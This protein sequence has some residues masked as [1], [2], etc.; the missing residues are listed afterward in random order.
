LTTGNHS[1]VTAKPSLAY[2]ICS[3]YTVV[4]SLV[5]I[6]N[7]VMN[8]QLSHSEKKPLRLNKYAVARLTLT[9]RQMG[10]IVA[11]NQGETQPQTGSNGIT[12][13]GNPC[14]TLPTV[15]HVTTGACTL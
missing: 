4:L 6:K 1:F 10:L 8:K 13:D 15:T 2:R 3:N 5:F 11:G 7:Q 9:D 12:A 14:T